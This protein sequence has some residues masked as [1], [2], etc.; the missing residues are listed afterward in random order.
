MKQT[1]GPEHRVIPPKELRI[2]ME[3]L[4]P[5][6]TKNFTRLP[7][8][9]RV[10]YTSLRW[11]TIIILLYGINARYVLNEMITSECFS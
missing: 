7:L 10:S 4:F 9:Y 3:W 1:R 11:I 6:T 5:E 8:Q 2:T